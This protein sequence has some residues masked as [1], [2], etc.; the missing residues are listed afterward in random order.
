MGINNKSLSFSSVLSFSAI[1]AAL[2]G[3]FKNIVTSLLSILLRAS[4]IKLALNPIFNSSSWLKRLD[5]I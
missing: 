3:P 5:I 2:K 4:K 1:I